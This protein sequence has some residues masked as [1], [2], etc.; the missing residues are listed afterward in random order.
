MTDSSYT[1]SR[2]EIQTYFDRTAIDLLHSMGVATVVQPTRKLLTTGGLKP[3]EEILRVVDEYGMLMI[4][5]YLIGEEG[6]E[7]PWRVFRHL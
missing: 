7:K 1:R 6:Q 2:S 3:D 4:R 5:P